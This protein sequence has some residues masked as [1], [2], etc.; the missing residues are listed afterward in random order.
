MGVIHRSDE[1]Q[2]T[3]AWRVDIPTIET[4]RLLTLRG[5]EAAEAANLTAYLCGIAVGN[6]SWK[7]VEINR[8]LFLR[9]LSRRGLFGPA[10]GKPAT[11]FGGG[12]SAA[13]DALG[14][15]FGLPY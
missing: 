6:G 9:D 3:G 13:A 8:L 2:E 7:L 14:S 12:L 10:D 11:R 5:L 15:T 4:V 1:I